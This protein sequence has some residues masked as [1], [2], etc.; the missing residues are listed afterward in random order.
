MRT[1]NS[2]V[3]RLARSW[4]AF[5]QLD[6]NRIVTSLKACQ[7]CQS[8]FP[9]QLA[10]VSPVYFHGSI[11]SMPPKRVPKAQYRA[12]RLE[13]FLRTK[14][15]ICFDDP[16]AA[17]PSSRLPCCRNFAH[18]TCLKSCFEHAFNRMLEHQRGRFRPQCP[19]CRQFLVLNNHD[20]ER[21]QVPPDAFHFAFQYI[22]YV[23]PFNIEALID[24][25]EQPRPLD[26]PRNIWDSV[27]R[28]QNERDRS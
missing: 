5:T 26:R 3:F 14:C 21:P 1:A 11:S 28:W 10:L 12:A 17:I 13:A 15:F 4:H 7:P 2:W 25:Y 24:N 19:V 9:L 23:P 6:P 8:D 27:R 20:E 18:E 16:S 22:T